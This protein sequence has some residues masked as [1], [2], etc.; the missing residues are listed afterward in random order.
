[1][2]EKIEFGLKVLSICVIPDVLTAIRCLYNA[3]C[4]Q[5]YAT[6]IQMVVCL[7]IAC[8]L[9][10]TFVFYIQWKAAGYYLILSFGYGISALCEVVILYYVNWGKIL[11]KVQKNT[12]MKNTAVLEVSNLSRNEKI[13]LVLRYGILFAIGICIFSFTCLF[14]FGTNIQRN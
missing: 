7:G 6:L 1:M 13:C 12:E 8:P 14:L 3:C 11:K 2:R 9:G 10:A 5:H 4:L